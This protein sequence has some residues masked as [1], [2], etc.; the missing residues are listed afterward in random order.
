MALNAMEVDCDLF[1]CSIIKLIQVPWPIPCTSTSTWHSLTLSS[2]Q[3]N[4]DVAM[5]IAA[6]KYSGQVA[7]G[8]GNSQLQKP[9][10]P[11]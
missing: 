2:S 4:F 7:Q 8:Y 5:K 1:L 6:I 10:Q 9:W 3:P 11:R